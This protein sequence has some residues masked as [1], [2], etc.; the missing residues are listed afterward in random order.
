MSVWLRITGWTAHYFML[1]CVS[2]DS[3][4]IFLISH[5]SEGDKRQADVWWQPTTSR[6]S[7]QKWVH[8]V[9]PWLISSLFQVNE[10][11]LFLCLPSLSSSRLL[12]DVNIYSKRDPL[13]QKRG[14]PSCL[15]PGMMPLFWVTL[16]SMLPC[17]AH[18]SG[19]D[20]CTIHEDSS[21]QNGK[22][23]HYS[24][25]ANWE[26]DPWKSIEM[27]IFWYFRP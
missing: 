27:Y 12:D 5:V 18:F 23:L 17:L 10:V 22:C 19:P 6:H 15:S 16:C 26:V 7:K 11:L 14:T 24:P 8:K 9:W 25:V 4:R 13:R 20:H 1:V 21:L 3:M 2:R